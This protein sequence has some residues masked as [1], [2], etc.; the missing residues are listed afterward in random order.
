MYIVVYLSV[1]RIGIFLIE[2]CHQSLFF[3]LPISSRTMMLLYN[4]HHT[5]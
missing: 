3:N 5:I 4:A 2:I 1:K